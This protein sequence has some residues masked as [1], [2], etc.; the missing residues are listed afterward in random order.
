M[1]A[2]AKAEP[3]EEDAQ[4]QASCQRGRERER[5]QSQTQTEMRR[6]EAERR[7]ERRASVRDK[8]LRGSS[9]GAYGGGGEIQKR[10]TPLQFFGQQ[11]SGPEYRGGRRSL[12]ACPH[13][14]QK[15]RKNRCP[16]A[17]VGAHTNTHTLEVKSVEPIWGHW[18]L[19]LFGEA[20]PHLEL[21]TNKQIA[22]EGSKREGV[23]G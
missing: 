10:H 7:A 2:F 23:P 21:S 11:Q 18:W 5:R 13:A 8:G 19:D 3:K 22:K 6:C 14:P 9:V 15:E 12:G 20:A 1:Q 17:P 16:S 4:P